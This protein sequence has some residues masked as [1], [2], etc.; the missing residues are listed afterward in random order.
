MNKV[1]LI[2]LLVFLSGCYYHQY[3]ISLYREIPLHTIS[4]GMNK[5][6]V[7][8]KMGKPYNVIGSKKYKEGTVEV[9]E[10]RKYEM[11]KTKTYD[12][13][14]E[15]YWLYFWNSKLEQWGRAGDWEKEADR[16]WEIRVR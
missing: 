5:D 12:S 16:I 4:V 1:F 7:L 13:L 11:S 14:L 2:L 9:W 3:D 8:E 6:N 10:Y 15:Q